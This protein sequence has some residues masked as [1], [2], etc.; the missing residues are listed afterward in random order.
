MDSGD[1]LSVSFRDAMDAIR[2]ACSAANR[3]EDCGSAEGGDTE[4]GRWT[5]DRDRALPG[6]GWRDGDR[7]WEQS[8]EGGGLGSG[9][10]GDNETYYIGLI[11]LNRPEKKLK[12]NFNQVNCLLRNSRKRE[13]LCITLIALLCGIIIALQRIVKG[14]NEY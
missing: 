10:E 5:G 14:S 13:P 4:E 3:A 11:Y 8:R 12:S 6:P 9:I 7:G 1:V 2:I